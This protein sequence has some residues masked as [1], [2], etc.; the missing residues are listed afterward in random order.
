MHIR[1]R[2]TGIETN[3]DDLQAGVDAGL[4]EIAHIHKTAASIAAATARPR[5]QIWFAFWCGMR[6]NWRRVSVISEGRCRN[7]GP[8]WP[9]SATN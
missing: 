5:A 2:L 3:L 1:N 9:D 8:A 6:T 7:C 4:R